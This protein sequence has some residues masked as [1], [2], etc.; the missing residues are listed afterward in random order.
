MA[1]D[2]RTAQPTPRP[3]TG[4]TV[5]LGPFAT[6]VVLDI[7]EALVLEQAFDADELPTEETLTAIVDQAI[8]PAVGQPPPRTT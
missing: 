1:I 8:L 6:M 4:D 3:V 7:G 5:E 2:T